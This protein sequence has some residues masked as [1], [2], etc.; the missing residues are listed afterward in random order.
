MGDF[1]ESSYACRIHPNVGKPIRCT[2]DEEQKEAVLAAMTRHVRLIGETI[3]VNNEIKGFRIQDIDIVD[4]EQFASGHEF[5]PFF[6]SEIDLDAL[7]SEQD[8]PAIAKFDDLL[9]KFWPESECVDEFLHAV[10]SWRRE[11]YPNAS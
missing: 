2:F 9:G 6:D 1:R 4:T 7:A 10:Q 5:H 3:E 11:E 8:V